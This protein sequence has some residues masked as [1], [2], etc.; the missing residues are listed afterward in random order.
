MTNPIIPSAAVGAVAATSGDEDELQSNN[1]AL[2]EGESN[3]DQDT[4]DED[5]AEA[6][7]SSKRLS[8]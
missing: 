7:E 1:P 6:A 2:D 8:E 3:D 5:V 4:V